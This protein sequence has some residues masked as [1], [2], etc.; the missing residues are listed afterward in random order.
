MKKESR[1]IRIM[2]GTPA[3]QIVIGAVLDVLQ[4]VKSE[5]LKPRV[6]AGTASDRPYEAA[7]AS[8][9][10]LVA[11]SA[12]LALFFFPRNMRLIYS[13]PFL[14]IF[15]AGASI[16]GMVQSLIVPSIN[17]LAASTSNSEF[18]REETTLKEDPENEMNIE[19]NSLKKDRQSPLTKQVDFGSRQNTI[20][21][22][23]TFESFSLP[24]SPKED[25]QRLSQQQNSHSQT[26]DENT[27]RE[28]LW[29]TLCKILGTST[30]EE[31]P[32]NGSQESLLQ[33][34][35][36]AAADV[37]F[38]EN[39]RKLFIYLRSLL[40]HLKSQGEKFDE[41]AD[42]LIVRINLLD[43]NSSEAQTSPELG[44]MLAML[45]FSESMRR[46]SKSLLEIRKF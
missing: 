1:E 2:V 38:D 11:G 29:S 18:V 44:P 46:V 40:L 30:L 5:R 42:K 9:G 35:T 39:T 45:Q 26:I 41:V 17:R 28:D 21:S 15:G 31:S 7:V 23:M 13:Y 3:L 27:T 36:G 37:K 32:S 20:D 19:T 12:G 10:G 25:S 24:S 33:T 6:D 34:P 43:K 4:M 16:F 8:I 14:C 22:R